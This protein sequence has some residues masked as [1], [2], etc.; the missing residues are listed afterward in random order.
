MA[1]FSSL[2]LS[3]SS[4]NPSPACSFPVHNHPR[5]LSCR[6]SADDHASPGRRN[7]LIGLGGLY[8][9][10]AGT[11]HSTN[12]DAAVAAPIQTPL[13]SQCGPADLPSGAN[14]VN[15][16]PPVSTSIDFKFPS[17]S[18]PLR[19]RRAAHLVDAEYLAKYTK[20]VHLMKDLPESDPRNFTQQANA[21]CAYCDGSYDQVGFPGVEIQVH[22]SWFFY[23]WHRFY[24]Y[25]HERILGKLLGDES[26]ALPFWN[27]DSPAGMQIPSF[28]T[29]T[30]SSLY[31]PRRDPSHQPPVIVDL[32]FSLNTS[33]DTGQALID[34]NLKLMYRQMIT[35]GST[36]E[37]FMGA[38]YSAG[39]QPDPGAGSVEN[40]PHGTVHIWTGDPRQPNREDMGILYSSS[41]DPI[42][43][44]HHS[45][46]DRL[47]DVWKTLGGNRKNYT[48][49]D[50]L[51]AS[52]YFYDENAKLVKVKVSD[53]LDARKLRY[54]YENVDNPWINAKPTR[55]G[56]GK[57]AELKIV[58]TFP[59][60]LSKSNAVASVKRPARSGRSGNEEEVLLVQGIEFQRDSF[61]KFD[62]Y[63]NA[64]SEEALRPGVSERAGSFVH[65]PHL[66]G[67]GKGATGKTTLKLGITGLIS[68]IGASEDD[69]LVVTLVPRSG[70]ATVAGISIVLSS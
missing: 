50:W 66:H 17:S 12:R 70:K 47:W 56:T 36:T 40:V 5:K 61:T 7:L 28:Y 25:F 8:G 44:A 15:C 67:K 35:N 23:P 11:N 58:S 3:I 14:P 43:F 13:P 34:D 57:A 64:S 52:F 6:A 24:L 32:D 2:L 51:N 9:A 54:T 18:T 22:N 21:H 1:S 62:V 65:V 69:R 38:K 63:V 41:R 16:C 45:N 48:D 68:E 30:S 31:D 53:T 49:S 26:F 27:W 59:V 10:T 29:D 33:T 4:V 46:I 42:F 19:V 39:D 37:L 55:G 20:A 60:T